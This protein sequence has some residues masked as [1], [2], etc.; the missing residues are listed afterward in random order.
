MIFLVENDKYNFVEY[1]KEFFM[2]ICRRVNKLEI[3]LL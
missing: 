1:V 2:S 3:H